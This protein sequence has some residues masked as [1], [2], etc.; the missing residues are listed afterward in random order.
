METLNLE[1]SWGTQY[2]P[3]KG[4]LLVPLALLFVEYIIV[5]S[6]IHLPL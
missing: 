3:K 5:F 1:C 4:K 2:W 6:Y